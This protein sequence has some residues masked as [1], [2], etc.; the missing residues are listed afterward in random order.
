MNFTQLKTKI[1]ALLDRSDYNAR[2]GEFINSAIH[3]L[4]QT[5][6]WRQMEAAPVTGNLTTSGDY[7][8]IPDRYKNV[9]S[10]FI[11]ANT[12]EKPLAKKDYFWI[13]SRYPYGTDGR[14]EPEVFATKTG[15][16]KFIIRPYPQQTYAYEL[17]YN[18][19]SADL[20]TDTNESNFWMSDMWEIVYYGALINYELDS[21]KKLEIGTEDAPL[22]PRIL[23]DSLLGKLMKT[24]IDEELSHYPLYSGADYVY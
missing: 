15:E 19:F 24:Q 21:G 2:A 6:D 13:K 5:Y 22:S 1:T 9:K 20:V 7:I 14:G 3:I 23:Y 16:S 12:R 10:L 17:I 11:T 4:E 18:A 8:A